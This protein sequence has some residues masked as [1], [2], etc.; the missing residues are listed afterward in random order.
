M[1]DIRFSDIFKKYKETDGAKHRFQKDASGQKGSQEK[2]D[3]QLSSIVRKNV[4]QNSALDINQLQGLYGEA[5]SKVKQVYQLKIGDE[6]DF[7]SWIRPAVDKVIDYFISGQKDI[8]RLCLGDY[9]EDEEY[10]YYHSVNVGIFA[11]FIGIG[12]EW[13]RERILELGI[14]GLIHDIGMTQCRQ[15]ADKKGILTK[16]E[17]TKVKEHPEKGFEQLKINARGLPPVILE[18]VLQEHERMDGS[19]YPKGLKEDQVGEYARIIGLVDVYEAITHKRPYRENHTPLE[20]MRTILD[21]KNSFSSDITKMLIERI[22]IFPAGLLVEFNTQEIGVVVK[23][24]AKLPLRPLIE[25]VIDAQG[26]ELKT[27]K[28]V[29]LADNS[30]IYIEQ[31]FDYLPICPKK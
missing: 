14:A 8:L 16:D 2:R 26:Q 15:L 7:V 20:A 30:V 24:N 29:D 19:G 23:S 28:Q 10:L 4:C 11:S 1:S 6:P 27:P 3:V 12:L 13:K 18:A 31:C 5:L 25:I 9:P 22:G 21:S 17:Y